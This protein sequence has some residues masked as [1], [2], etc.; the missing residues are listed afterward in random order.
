[1]VK[2][3]NLNITKIPKKPSDCYKSREVLPLTKPNILYTTYWTYSRAKRESLQI[4]RW[5]SI[6]IPVVNSGE[7]AGGF[8]TSFI[9]LNGMQGRYTLPTT[10]TVPLQHFSYWHKRRLIYTLCLT[11]SLRILHIF[12]ISKWYA[13]TVRF[14]S[15]TLPRYN[16][17][18]INIREGLSTVLCVYTLR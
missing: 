4:P 7:T 5:Y 13:G 1:M 12:Y 3:K 6:Y 16:T 10:H 9:Y 8:C 15:H 18:V 11:L 17:S 2:P 14:L